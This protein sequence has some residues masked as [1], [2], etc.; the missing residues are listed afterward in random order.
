MPV[1]KVLMEMYHILQGTRPFFSP[2]EVGHFPS[3]EEKAASIFPSLPNLP[4]SALTGKNQLSREL[5]FPGTRTLSHE[6]TE[7]FFLVEVKF[8]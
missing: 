3:P 1:I 5:R 7:S 4:Q 2:L 8:T 6:S